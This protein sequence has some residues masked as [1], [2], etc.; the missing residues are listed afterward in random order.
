MKQFIFIILFALAPVLLYSQ[1]EKTD[2]LDYYMSLDT[3]VKF[4][5]HNYGAKY[6]GNNYN[7]VASHLLDYIQ[8]KMGYSQTRETNDKQGN[9]IWTLENN[10]INRKVRRFTVTFYLQDPYNGYGMRI[11]KI[12]MTGSWEPIAYLF[13]SYWPTSINFDD[14]TKGATATC[15]YSTDYIR[16]TSNYPNARLEV[17][18][19]E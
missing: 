14:K 3:S 15:R 7:R 5:H 10:G 11:T 4:P 2:S 6:I 17:T 19:Y 9:I 13:C 1:Q 8:R 12:A 16:V 18:K